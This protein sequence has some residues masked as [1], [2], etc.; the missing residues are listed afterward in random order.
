MAVVPLS[1]K[2]CDRLAYAA[3]AAAWEVEPQGVAG[4]K[5]SDEYRRLA[6][7]LRA[8]AVHDRRPIVPEDTKPLRTGPPPLPVDT[9]PGCAEGDGI[10][11]CVAGRDK[12]P[13]C[14]Q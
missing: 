9:F 1:A 10:E 12:H 6:A 14:Y 5:E 13:G 4:K 11:R 8:H 3:D 2:D 7:L